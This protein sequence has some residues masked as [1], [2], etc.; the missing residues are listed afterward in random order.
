[1]EWSE[2]LS[3]SVSILISV[4][5]C[6][7]IYHTKFAAYMAVSFI[8]FFSYSSGSI[9][10]HCI[11]GCMFLYASVYFCILC[12]LIVM[13]VPFWVFRFIVLFCVLCV[14][15]CVLDYCHQVSTQMQLH[16][17]IYQ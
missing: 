3:N 9:L 4:C 13:Y 10:Y 8:T 7:Y 1:M 12:I 11:Y 17:S 6:V 16:I 15:K 5:V 14:C 2:G